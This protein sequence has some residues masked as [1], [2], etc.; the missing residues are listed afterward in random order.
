VRCHAAAN[1][2]S[3]T[4]GYVRAWSVATS[5]GVTLVAL[6]AWS[7]NRRDAMASRLAETSTSRDAADA[8]AGPGRAGGTSTVTE[9]PFEGSPA[10]SH[11]GGT[12]E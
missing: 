9:S 12:V 7:K 8:R 11:R 3:R 5:I 1:S 6:M 2:S 4:A 10:L